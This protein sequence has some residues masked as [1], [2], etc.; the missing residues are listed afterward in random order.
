[1]ASLIGE[2][3]SKLDEKGRF[4][5]PAA[6]R[7]QLD[8][9]DQDDFVMNRG[10]EGCLVLYPASEWK[11]ETTQMSELNLY[12]AKNRKFYRQFHN[13]ATKINPDN[14]GRILIPKNLKG[15]AQIEK[16][17][18]VFAYANRIELWAKDQYLSEVKDGLDDFASLAEEV[19]GSSIKNED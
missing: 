6:L 3:E 13:G 4:L 14:T 19:M 11:K 5:L 2:Y 18:V 10:F 8:P 16:E 15:H 7:K 17:L 1:M 9:S 12:V